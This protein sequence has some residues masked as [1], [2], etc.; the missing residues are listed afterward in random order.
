MNLVGLLAASGDLPGA[1]AAAGLAGELTGV[2]ADR[3]AANVACAMARAGQI[4]DAH[5]VAAPAMRRLRR[6]GDPAALMGLLINLGLARAMCGDLK[7][8]E[9]FLAEAVAA[10]EEAGLR[11]L[12][13]M[14]RGNL[15]F[16]VARRG[17][18]PRA[19]GL[20]VDSEAG[21]T[22]E[23]L[24]QC[25]FDQAEALMGVG[26]TGEARALLAV[27]LGAARAQGYAC[28][29]ADGL[30]L[31]AYAELADGDCEQ[32]A[33]T[34]EQ[35][36]AVFAEQER[37]GWM[38]VAEH[39]LLRARWSSGERSGVF[40]RTAVAAAERM[41]RG[42]W[43]EASVEARIIAARVA[44]HLRR[45][46]GHLLEPVRDVRGSARLKVAAWHAEA[47]EYHTRGDKR[48]AVSAVWAGLRVL[49]EHAEVFGALE[50]RA[51]SAGMGEEL[52]DLG[53]SLARSARELLTTEERRRAIVRRPTS[54]RPPADPE[55]AA[56]LTELRMLSSNH[57]HAT[58]RGDVSAVDVERLESAIRASA[59]RQ[60][61]V[62]DAAGGSREL[63]SALECRA[64]VEMIR[65]GSELH[66]VTAADGRMRRHCLGSYDDVK[67]EVGTVRFGLGRGECGADQ[68]DGLLFGPLL[69][70][71]GERELVIA[72]TGVLHALPWSVLPCLAERPF[73]IVPSAASWL[74]AAKSGR[75]GHVVLAAGPDLS[76]A[77]RELS[78]LQG[79][80]PKAHMPRTAK[81]VHEAMEGASL[82]HI[83]AHGEFRAD[84][85]LFSRLRLED[86]PL[87]AY[88]LEELTTPPEII[89][90]SACDVGRAAADD[91]VIG[92]VGVL[93][94]LGTATVIASVTPV[95]DEDAPAFMLAFHRGLAAG[96]SPRQAL[97]ATPRTPGTAGFLCF[98][99]G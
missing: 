56:A 16:V 37:A 30:L 64:L 96:L 41:E 8:A 54:V 59:L 44:L 70:D 38:L 72:P 88:D 23:R 21:L 49:E 57:A 22:E 48:G 95:R 61:G 81:D 36:R 75:P 7:V 14:A 89:V 47:L 71:L 53:L 11:Y 73:T 76:H 86:G 68:L 26:L 32:A 25:R 35:A 74:R 83:A 99:A 55:R 10:G 51:R 9:G 5:Q 60:P 52:A 66:A 1:F 93:L 91:A 46:A 94:G 3:L 58:A 27:A 82:V 97:A 69:E 33:A 40:L 24:V 4:T 28:D 15:A 29:V 31:L 80:Y 42:G 90:L 63:A 65:I 12:T 20:F 92:M 77:E 19:L 67:R 13:A 18:V 50:L 43:A 45:P 6:G 84:N 17:D 34:A 2:D 85:A 87:M 62:R 79:L 39:V 98:G 78:G